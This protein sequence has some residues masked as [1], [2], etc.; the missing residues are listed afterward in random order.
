MKKKNITIF[1][2]VLIMLI[3]QVALFVYYGKT[4]EESDSYRNQEANYILVVQMKY[5]VAGILQMSE[6]EKYQ[7]I[8]NI[9]LKNKNGI[10]ISRLDCEG[11]DKL[12]KNNI[13]VEWDMENNKVFYLKDSFIN[14][15]TG[16]FI[17][18]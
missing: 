16:Q 17:C 13:Q 10:I 18:P 2:T 3:V 4:L 1:S 6:D 7:Y 11:L 8:S 5:T 9:T 12:D 15:S 14:I